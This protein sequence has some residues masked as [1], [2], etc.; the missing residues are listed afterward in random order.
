MNIFSSDASIF[1][2]YG[3]GSSLNYEVDPSSIPSVIKWTILITDT[4]DLAMDRIDLSSNCAVVGW[5]IWK[6]RDDLVFNHIR[7]SPSDTIQRDT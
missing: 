4:I 1:Q 5:F 3:F 7:V 2:L 6:A